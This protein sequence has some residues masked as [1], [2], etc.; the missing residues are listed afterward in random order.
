[1]KTRFSYFFWIIVLALGLMMLIYLAQF[2]TNRNVAGLQKGNREAAITFSI[3]NS[4]QEIINIVFSLETRLTKSKIAKDNL[5]GIKD[6]LTLIGYNTSILSKLNLDTVAEN[7]FQRLNKEVANMVSVSQG[8]ITAIEKDN[9][10]MQKQYIDSLDGLQMSDAI[11]NT[12]IQTTKL[13]ENKLQTTLHQNTLNSR[14]LS[15]YNKILALIAIA[16]ILILATIIINRHLWQLQLIGDLEK[17]NA[18]VEKSAIIKEQF[19]ANMSHEIRTPLNAIIGFS[20]IITQSQLTNEQKQYIDIIENASNQL[21]QIVNDVLD[22]SKIESGKLQIEAR[23]LNIKDILQMFESMFGNSAREKKILYECTIDEDMPLEL[24]GDRDHL[25]QI[26]NNLISNAIK[27]TSSGYVKI[28]AREINRVGTKTWI[29]FKV[30]DS[31]TG[32]SADNVDRIFER[33]YQ[34]ANKD[35]SLIKG[36]GLGLAIVKNLADLMGGEVTLESQLGKGSLFTVTLPFDINSNKEIIKDDSQDALLMDLQFN[37]VK[38]LVAEDNRV[39]Q[40]LVK[41]LL[42]KY[43]I[44]PVFSQNGWEVIE[45]LQQETFDLLLMDIQMPVMNGFQAMEKIKELNLELPVIAMT[46]FVMS[47]DKE[48]CLDAGMDDYLSKPISELQLQQ[49]LLRFLSKKQVLVNESENLSSE[50][51]LVKLA[52][53]D[54][55][56]ANIILKEVK[57]QLRVEIQNLEDLRYQETEVPKLRGFCHHLVSTI[58]PLGTDT[59]AMK[60]IKNIQQKLSSNYTPS[61]I[62][63]LFNELKKEL[64]NLRDKLGI[65]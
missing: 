53:G 31:G 32:I 46:A 6:S 43:A 8:L 13:L 50:D 11:Y 45:T 21:L 2:F 15:T 17:A 29:Q 61:E 51:F 63:P 34:V 14:S 58:S 62:R 38:I 26:L 47:G 42:N 48:K 44:E 40:L 22:I 54:Q 7:M 36:T 23:E 20:G 35:G 56:M 9:I 5:N 25:T 1:M 65:I 16:A 3:Q 10:S 30:E 33:F 57:K 18:Q 49:V 19:L 64:E 39:N 55:E 4:L 59:P 52:G 27:F 24:I 37:N 28:N 41:Y 12:A 60:C